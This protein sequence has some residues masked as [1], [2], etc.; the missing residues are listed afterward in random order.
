MNNNMRTFLDFVAQ[1]ILA[2]HGHQLA[3]TAV[4]FPNKRA[5]LFF[6]ESLAKQSGRPM[7][8]PAYMTISELFRN[9][10]TRTVGDQIKLICD[11]Y[12]C[13]VGV[14]GINET[15]DH[16]YGWGQLLLADFDDI[17]KNM[18]DADKV[19]ANVRDIHELDDLSYLSDEQKAILRKF[20]SNFTDNHHTELKERFLRLWCHFGDIYHRFNQ[21]L[22]EQGLAYEGALY[23]QVAADEIED[24]SYDR[25]IFVGFNLVQKVEQ[26]LFDKLKKAGRA[27]FYW[28]FDKYYM[29]GNEAG[30][31][32]RQYL[33]KFP[34]E[35]DNSSDEIYNN[36]RRDKQ[37]T[38]VSATTE[39]IQARYIAQWLK[40]NS[41]IADGKRTAVVLCNEALLPMA[42]HCL[43]DEVEKV[44][45]TTGYPL[46]QSPI[47]SLIMQLF[48]LQT[49]GY[50][51]KSG[52]YRLPY[53]NKVLRHP[54]AQFLSA[55]H[56]T[57]CE[58]LNSN[59]IYYSTPALL[60]RDAALTLLFQEPAGWQSAQ[61]CSWLMNVLRLLAENSRGNDYAS[62]DPLFA[63]SLYRAYTLLN[64]LNGLMEG[65]DL[66]ID[67][68][69]MHRLL[70]QLIQSTSVPFHGEPAIGLQMM[71]VLETRNLDFDHV[72]M[73]SCNEGNMPRGVND[74]SFI[75]Y[76]I[77]KA[78]DLTT[79]DHKVAIYSY[80]FHRLLQRATDVTLVYNNATEDGKT[81]EMSRFM[82]QMLVESGHSIAQ[83]SLHAGQ[84]VPTPQR[85]SVGKTPEVLQLLCKR[86][87]EVQPP[88][89]VGAQPPSAAASA[90]AN[91]LPLLTPSAIN[92]Y[93][94]CPLK[95]Y[96]RYVA[97]LT[98]LDENEDDTIDGRVFG[99]I[100][101][102]AAHR[103]YEQLGFHLEAAA[104]DALLKNKAEIARHV[105]NAIKQELFRLKTEA[106]MPELNGLQI[107]NREV[108][109]RY[110]TQLLRID[111]QLA[112]FDILG[113]EMPVKRQWTVEPAGGGK[114]FVTTL[115]GTIDRLDCVTEHGERKIRVVDYKTGR[116][117]LEPMPDVEAIFGQEKIEKHSDYYLQ[118]FLYSLIVR[119]D[120]GYNP[121]GLKVVP[122]LFFVQQSSMESYNPVLKMGREVVA[123]ISQYSQEL[124][125]RLQGVVNE[126]FSP[127]I[128]FKPTETTSRCTNCPFAEICM[129]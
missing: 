119:N 34:N 23:R 113:L 44:N 104:I 86:F 68:T 58:E 116:A 99:N 100:F 126:I 20:F 64:R 28:D 73:L 35:L 7:W 30:H 42:I 10:S 5:S 74:T 54:Y 33:D 2:K 49:A 91:S 106:R 22:A 110:L 122:A 97:G 93:L 3:R 109:I 56:A 32:I 78:F 66:T 19:F 47:S 112:P 9:H 46:S 38:F 50:V 63:E 15:L 85:H 83:V 115:G 88:S 71:G 128:P 37:I 89:A 124:E 62:R 60:A 76:N 36:F 87:A 45:I 52:T 25:Y 111:R 31:F 24:F 57:L 4:V 41:R 11:L 102:E 94:S 117:R 121:Q 96:Y 1:D 27:R 14:T 18:A 67:L 61:L 84:H 108:I 129:A 82:L 90:T 75:P 59:H 26:Q 17:D 29:G 39:N 101:H 79:I 65:G 98:E 21:L 12:K 48:A 40:Q 13:F 81:G 77:R 114:A 118:T 72:L 125:E 107:I 105:D 123:D 70:T 103:I 55:Q 43:P 51:R 53:V 8:S 120:A 80:Y 69:T 16:F 92:R 127:D 6:S 95:F